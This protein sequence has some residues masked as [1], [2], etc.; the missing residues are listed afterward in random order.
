MEY[1]DGC[2]LDEVLAE[3]L[4]LPHDWVVDIMDQ[5]CSAVEEAHRQG[6]I[7]RDLKPDNIW[8]E[9][10]HRGGFTVK[11][12]DFG[13]AKLSDR[14]ESSAATGEAGQTP[15]TPTAISLPPQNPSLSGVT[16]QLPARP[17][18]PSETD[19]QILP[20]RGKSVSLADEEAEHTLMLPVEKT[21]EIQPT[22]HTGPP[23]GLT[24]VGSI[25]GTPP[26][27]SPEQCLGRPLDQRSDIYSLGVIAYQMLAGQT[28]FTGDAM[29]VIRQQ[30]E[31]PPPPLRERRRNVPKRMAAVIMAALAKNPG[32]R[33]T[34]AAAFASA[35]S[36]NAEGTGDLL[37]RAFMLYS[38][39]F[40]RFLRLSLLVNLPLVVISL[41]GLL[42]GSLKAF[43]LAP[44]AATTIA[45]VVFGLI[46]FVGNLVTGPVIYATTT[47]LVAQLQ[48]A[49][50]RPVR[51]R[52]ALLALKKILRP[53]MVTNLLVTVITFVGT[54]MCFFP[55][56]YL[57]IA[58][59]LYASVAMMEGRFGRA[60]LR[61][62]KELVKR[63]KRTAALVTII[64]FV[65]PILVAGILTTLVLHLGEG[66]R[67][68]PVVPSRDINI[69]IGTSGK[70]HEFSGLIS[71]LIR[72]VVNIFTLPLGA[73]LC[74][75][76]YLKTRQAGGETLREMLAPIEE[77][78]LPKSQWQRRMHERLQ[79]N[80][81][82]TRSR[83]SGE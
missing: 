41:L 75:L 81:G 51:I 4:Q 38:Q 55:G 61:R 14:T 74:S 43:M 79:L 1:L 30:I 7:H 13:L 19:T 45:Q 39:H 72:N 52:P 60:A 33:P 18:G 24:R 66:F 71:E 25:M 21:E 77:E 57:L 10:N 17:A 29:S 27:M 11:V 47:R 20:G 37:R 15:G 68:A 80:S 22:N 65:I 42:N 16:L 78:E 23:E 69:R 83:R 28:P 53:F 9:P 8:L 54:I 50:L 48:A 6:I 34:S 56:V 40:P 2:T 12:L 3:E 32:D 64:Q 35:L 73:I 59:S 58:Y 26:Y 82:N 36:A 67:D 70:M 46:L 63:S 76:L 49:P 44:R 5:V 62:S 31:A